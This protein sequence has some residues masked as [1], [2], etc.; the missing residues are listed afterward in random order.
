MRPVWKVFHKVQ[1]LL[2]SPFVCKWRIF[3][4]AFPNGATS[5]ASFSRGFGVGS[6]S[7]HFADVVPDGQTSERSVAG[8]GAYILLH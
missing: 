3:V 8:E 1:T 6:A 2:Y 7:Q 5:T 4:Y